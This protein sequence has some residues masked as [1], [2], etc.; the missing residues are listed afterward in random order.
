MAQSELRPELTLEG[1]ELYKAARLFRK[2]LYELS[3]QLPADEKFNLCQQMRRAALSVTANIAEAHGRFH[4][5]DASRF[6][7]QS[8]GSVSEIL[9]Q[10]NLCL[11]EGYGHTENVD[12]LKKRTYDLIARINGYVSY[13][14]KRCQDQSEE[15]LD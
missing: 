7:L 1:F 5:R 3:R 14:R 13:L 11:D 6:Y 2:D 12:A 4:F 8:R 15:K 9:D 10:L